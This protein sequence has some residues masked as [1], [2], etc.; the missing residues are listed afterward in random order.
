MIRA[1]GGGAAVVISR[2]QVV[3]FIARLQHAFTFSWMIISLIMI[4]TANMKNKVVIL[5]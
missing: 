3:G 2:R 1:N 4:N 5:Y